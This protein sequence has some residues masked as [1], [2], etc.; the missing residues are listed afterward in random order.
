MCAHYGLPVFA[1][2]YN[3][4]VGGRLTLRYQEGMIELSPSEFGEEQTD[5]A[6]P[7]ATTDDDGAT[8]PEQSKRTGAFP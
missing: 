5:E 7:T 1:P 2:R 8:V 6:A 4:A 3:E